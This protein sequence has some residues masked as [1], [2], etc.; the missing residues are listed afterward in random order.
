[1]SVGA[2]R[3]LLI[4]ARGLTQEAFRRLPDADNRGMARN[5]GIVVSASALSALI[6]SAVFAAPGAMAAG[7][8]T[9]ANGFTAAV[10]AHSGQTICG[11][12]DATG[13]AP[14][15]YIGPGVHGVTVSGA[16]VRGGQ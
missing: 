13:Y 1:M 2:P 16:T 15:N 5:E 9:L 6:S 12:I 7:Q 4:A 10:I 8:T 11:L 14:G 3:R